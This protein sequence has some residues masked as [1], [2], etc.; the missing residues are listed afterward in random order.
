MSHERQSSWLWELPRWSSDEML[1]GA[2]VPLMLIL[3]CGGFR[4]RHRQSS[5]W[6]LN[7]DSPVIIRGPWTLRGNSPD[8]PT[9]VCRT[10]H[11]RNVHSIRVMRSPFQPIRRFQAFLDV[12]LWQV[13]MLT[14]AWIRVVF[15]VTANA[16]ITATLENAS[17]SRH[18]S[19]LRSSTCNQQASSSTWTVS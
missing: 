2:T 5:R 14:N 17:R 11:V 4:A 10:D 3:V 8:L 15:T 16:G 13:G 7:N 6:C 9:A 19:G 18:R 1:T 12:W